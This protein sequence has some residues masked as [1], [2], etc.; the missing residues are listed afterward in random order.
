MERLRTSPE[1]DWGRRGTSKLNN[2]TTG[3]LCCESSLRSGSIRYIYGARDSRS[4]RIFWFAIPRPFLN[5]EGWNLEGRYKM[6]FRRCILYDLPIFNLLA[7]L[8]RFKCR[9]SAWCLYYG[10]PVRF[11]RGICCADLQTTIE[12]GWHLSRR[13]G[14]LRK[15]NLFVTILVFWPVGL[16]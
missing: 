10:R 1:A 7:E 14:K 5:V 6:E 2:Q 13:L 15:L 11:Y 4:G 12:C 3:A 8:R 16:F 9:K